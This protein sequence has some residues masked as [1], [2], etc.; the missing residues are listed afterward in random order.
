MAGHCTVGEA[1]VLDGLAER[2]G[3]LGASA[4]G[5]TGDRSANGGIEVRFRPATHF[6]MCDLVRLVEPQRTTPR[7]SAVNTR[8]VRLSCNP[9]DQFLGFTDRPKGSSLRLVGR[10]EVQATCTYTDRA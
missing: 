2:R 5:H 1:G 7:P 3:V 9:G 8:A 10:Y 6:S 4:Q